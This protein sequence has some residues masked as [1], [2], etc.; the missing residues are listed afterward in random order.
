MIE[1]FLKSLWSVGVYIANECS[2]LEI[3][4][5]TVDRGRGVTKCFMVGN[6]ISRV[7]PYLN[8]WNL[9]NN[10]RNMKKGDIID[11]KTGNKIKVNGKEIDVSIAIEFCNSIDGNKIAF[12]QAS[13]MIDGR[14]VAN[15]QTTKI[16]I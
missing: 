16:R 1:L 7:C 10:I 2:K 5:N 4:Y 9:L 14:R 12:G 8:D 11:V 13:S 15:R 6:T 3:F